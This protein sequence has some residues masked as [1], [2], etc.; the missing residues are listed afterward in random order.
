MPSEGYELLPS[1]AAFAP[2][3]SGAV[4]SNINSSAGSDAWTV[5]RR[6]RILAPEHEPGPLPQLTEGMFA[7]TTTLSLDMVSVAGPRLLFYFAFTFVIH[8]NNFSHIFYRGEAIGFRQQRFGFFDG[9]NIFSHLHFIRELPFRPFNSRKTKD[10]DEATTMDF[11]AHIFGSAFVI[12]F[13]LRLRRITANQYARRTTTSIL[14]IIIGKARIAQ[15]LMVI[16][17]FFTMDRC[18]F[19]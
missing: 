2:L 12:S 3:S 11:G 15:V 14:I 7:H 10:S 9:V 17:G 13:G 8:G 16:S 18:G 5:P 19:S 1:A 6:P 4:S